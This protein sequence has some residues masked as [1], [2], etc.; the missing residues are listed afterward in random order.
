MVAQESLLGLAPRLFE[1]GVLLSFLKRRVPEDSSFQ[2]TKSLKTSYS[3][4]AVKV[5][6]PE[7][8]K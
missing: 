4:Y 3:G 8:A 7:L 5:L 6:H 2:F 1:K